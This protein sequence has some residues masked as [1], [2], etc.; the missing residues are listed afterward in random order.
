MTAV[1]LQ[2]SSWGFRLRSLAEASLGID[3]ASTA[4]PSIQSVS[5]L[6]IVFPLLLLVYA[7]QRPKSRLPLANPR[8]FFELSDSRVKREFISG[9]PDIIE[10]GFSLTGNKPFRIIADIG[11]VTILPPSLAN[12]V[13]NNKNLSFAKYMYRNFHAH[14]PGFEAFIEGG[15]DSRLVKHVSQRQLTTTLNK[16]TVPLSEECSLSLQEIFTDNE[17]WHDIVLK[18]DIIRI[19]ARLSSKVLLGDEL[20]HDARWLKLTAQYT[21]VAFQAAQYL[22]IF[23]YY[24]RYFIHWLLP[25]CW[26]ARAQVKEARSI[27]GP[28]LKQRRR[29]NAALQAQGKKLVEY[30]DSIEW[31]E[32]AAKGTYY[33]PA[34]S[35]LMM[36]FSSIHTSAD[37][38]TQTIFDLA[39]HLEMIAPLRKEILAVLGEHGWTK[40]ALY[41]LKLMDSVVKETQRLK[42]VLSASM[43]RVATADVKLSDG[44][45]IRKDSMVAV[46]ARGQRDPAVYKD[47]DHWDG[48]R[49]YNM[50]QTAGHE[51]VAQLVSTSPDHLGFG[52]GQH[53]CPGRFFAANEV[54]IFLC[55]FLLKYDFK[56]AEGSMPRPR[57]SGF[58]INCDP[59]AKI[60][61]RRRQG[62]DLSVLEA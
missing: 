47:P 2:N 37:L 18:D 16:I 7:L 17:W 19:V 48:Y 8:R 32:Q 13:R 11:E 33:D 5:Y 25:G 34:I 20:C 6:I 56:L 28:V 40:I 23:P 54:K 50:R 15:R 26:S 62:V 30:N 42:P 51:C 22:R 58:H 60:S 31:F 39:E 10:K 36:S 12:E 27:I 3:F 29:Q 46:S 21:T 61:L 38:I 49:F 43:R 59:V 1:P 41:K 24:S 53:A 45:T 55:H 57:C 35:Q 4:Y 52:H 44:T 14:L 9:A